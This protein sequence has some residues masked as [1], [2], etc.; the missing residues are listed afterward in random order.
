MDTD[1]ELHCTFSELNISK[2]S[3]NMVDSHFQAKPCSAQLPRA[4]ANSQPSHHNQHED[5]QLRN[6]QKKGTAML[7]EMGQLSDL[8]RISYRS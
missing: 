4:A 1:L 7:P 5:Q 6:G 3:V 2:V 8:D